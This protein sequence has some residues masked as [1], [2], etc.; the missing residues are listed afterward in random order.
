MNLFRTF[1][2]VIAIQNVMLDLKFSWE[3]LGL[4]HMH[5]FAESGYA[6]LHVFPQF[7]GVGWLIHR[8]FFLVQV[9]FFLAGRLV[10][11]WKLRMAGANQQ[12][13]RWIRKRWM[14]AVGPELFVCTCWCFVCWPRW[15]A[16]YFDIFVDGTFFEKVKLSKHYNFEEVWRLLTLL[17]SPQE[18][19]KSVLSPRAPIRKCARLNGK[20]L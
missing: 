16:S 14:F 18:Q 9:G 1:H 13:F 3:T 19:E 8:L 5:E 10:L 12:Y 11:R 4:L 15:F 20:S 17:F 6:Q 2:T 7:L